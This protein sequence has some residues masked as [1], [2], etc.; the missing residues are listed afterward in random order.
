MVR[1]LMFML[2]IMAITLQLKA[3]MSLVVRPISDAEKITALS[4]VGKLVYSGDSLFLYDNTQALIYSEELAKVQHVRYSDEEPPIVV[5]DGTVDNE[6]QVSVYPNPTIDL[7]FIDNMKGEIRLYTADGRLL[8]VL[9]G[10]EDRI[11]VDMS[12][13]PA[14]I[15]LLFCG[16]EA[17]NVIKK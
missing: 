7:L 9:E 1:K 6:L 3:E 2:F 16:G 8:Q 13:Y 14:G 4:H 5:G 10:D 17:F 12:A 11:E 15:Y